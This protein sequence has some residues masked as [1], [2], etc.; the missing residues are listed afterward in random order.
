M[1]PVASVD[2]LTRQSAQVLV[3]LLGLRSCAFEVFPF[4]VQLPRIE[5]GR[6]V[7][8]AEEPGI[9]TWTCNRGIELP[10]RHCDLTVGRF[11]LTPESPSVGVTL[12]PHARAIALDIA[13]D[14]GRVVADVLVG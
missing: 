6:I 3:Q 7:L 8:P 4:D 1:L 10:V 13:A 9:E 12:S 14:V 5:P 2:E 11:V